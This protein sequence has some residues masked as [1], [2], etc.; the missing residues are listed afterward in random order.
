MWRGFGGSN[1]LAVGVQNLP[2]H[3]GGFRLLALVFNYGAQSQGSRIAAYRCAHRAVPLAQVQR[4]G[5]GEPHMTI[6]ARALI[7][8]SIAEAGVDA[9]NDVILRA[10]AQEICQVEPERDI[11]VVVAADEAAV[12]ENQ[13]TAEGA[14]EFD[15]NA[16][17]QIACGNLKFAAVPAYAGLWI[18]SA[19]GLKA[20]RVLDCVANKG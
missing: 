13:H 18:A 16:A 2:A 20:V 6:N 19:D 3:F 8:P 10:I 9:R 7:E 15:R 1:S 17:A 5:L 14:V 12:D 4:I 11:A